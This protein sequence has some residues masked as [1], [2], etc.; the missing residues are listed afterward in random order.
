MKVSIQ[1]SQVCKADFFLTSRTD[2]NRKFRYTAQNFEVNRNM[3]FSILAINIIFLNVITV[4]QKHGALIYLL[5]SVLLDVDDVT[6]QWISHPNRP[7]YKI[8]V[9]LSGVGLEKFQ[10]FYFFCKHRYK[11]ETVSL[12]IAHI[13]LRLHFGSRCKLPVPNW[14]T[15]NH[16]LGA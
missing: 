3:S 14:Q 10:I 8:W 6:L 12:Y 7:E 1:S 9:K 15:V 4:E 2:I 11:T 16:C 5:R 13:W